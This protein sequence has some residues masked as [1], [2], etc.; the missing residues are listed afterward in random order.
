M[1]KLLAVLLAGLLALVP[2]AGFAAERVVVAPA[3]QVF[4]AG[5]NLLRLYVLDLA[6]ADCMLLTDG[7]QHLLIDAGKQNQ[8]PQLKALLE[9]LGIKSVSVFNTHPH[10]DHAGGILPLMNLLH[11]EAF[12]N[13]FPEQMSGRNVVQAEVLDALRAG[14][15]P[16]QRLHTGDMV[17]FEGA[18]IRVFQWA[19]GK[20][21]NDQSAVLHVRYGDAALLLTADIGPNGQ[22]YFVDIPGLEADIVKVPHHGIEMLRSDFLDAVNPAYAFFTHGRTDTPNTW[23]RLNS[24][25]T[26]Y[27]FAARGII[28][29]TTDGTRWSA[30]QVGKSLALPAQ[31]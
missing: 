20:T 13:T 31:E 1:R 11:I 30:E 4:A 26:P 24:R 15:V 6:G 12:Y 29:L 10:G 5:E 3:E 27:H 28:V 2:A 18:D 25:K 7:R 23:R 17:P 14:G 9:H 19:E 21:V 22:K 8:H 16:V